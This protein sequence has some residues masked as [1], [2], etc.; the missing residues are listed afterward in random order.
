MARGNNSSPAIIII[1]IVLVVLII[2]TCICGGLLVMGTGLTLDK[3]E[4]EQIRS[5]GTRT[6]LKRI[7]EEMHS[8]SA[9]DAEVELDQKTE[10]QDSPI[11]IDDS[12]EE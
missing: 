11:E 2:P 1:V 8:A 4:M 6:E 12:P 9:R 10:V 7:G 3:M 5:D